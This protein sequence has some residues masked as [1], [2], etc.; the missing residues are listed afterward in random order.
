MK[1]DISPPNSI[2]RLQPWTGSSFGCGDEWGT[3][4]L[5]RSW[6]RFSFGG[7]FL[8]EVSGLFNFCRFVCVAAAPLSSSAE[9]SVLVVRGD[10]RL[11]TITLSLWLVRG[12]CNGSCLFGGLLASGV[13]AFWPGTGRES[14]SMNALLRSV[15]LCGRDLAFDS[16]ECGLAV[17]ISF[18]FSGLGKR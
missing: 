15:F 7:S 12:C 9:A 5:W 11:R 3:E 4:L 8:T 18:H 6:C 10:L 16:F 1:V 13:T 14:L 2:L 17:F